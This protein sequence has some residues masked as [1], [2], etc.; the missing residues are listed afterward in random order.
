M[1]RNRVAN[2]RG[3]IYMEDD[4]EEGEKSGSCGT[5]RA[6][7]RWSKI[8]RVMGEWRKIIKLRGDF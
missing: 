7:V 8:A 6:F 2:V 3:Y 4:R 1:H 5:M